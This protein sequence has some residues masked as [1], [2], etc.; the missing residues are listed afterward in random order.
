VENVDAAAARDEPANAQR[1]AVHERDPFEREPFVQEALVGIL[2]NRRG[3]RR[4]AKPH[5]ATI[6]SRGVHVW[7]HGRN[8][9]VDV[10]GRHAA[11]TAM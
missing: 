1:A 7:A 10:G 4:D 9:A 2:R 3:E 8:S 11:C 5:I 6:G